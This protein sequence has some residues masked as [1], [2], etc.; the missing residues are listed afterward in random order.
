MV[1]ND[2][3]WPQAV[4][5]GAAI[6]AGLYEG[7]V[8]GL[9]VMDIWQATLMRAVATKKLKDD[10][11]GAR[12]LLGVDSENLDDS[13]SLEEEDFND[14]EESDE[15]LMSDINQLGFASA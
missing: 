7:S 11:D 14:D 15:V 8:S 1:P 6:Q 12:A 2:V 13:E 9:M 5:L 4:A 3:Y 10:D